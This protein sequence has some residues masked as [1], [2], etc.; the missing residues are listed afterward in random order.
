MCTPLEREIEVS[1]V[2]YPMLLVGLP[3]AIEPEKRNVLPKWLVPELWWGTISVQLPWP[4]V[5]THQL[6]PCATLTPTHS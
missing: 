1:G 6:M 4:S 5:K 3:A 2:N